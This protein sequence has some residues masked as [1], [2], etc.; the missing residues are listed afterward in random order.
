[1]FQI[2]YQ[3]PLKTLVKV[4]SFINFLTKFFNSDPIIS[5]LCGILVNH[6]FVQEAILARVIG[7]VIYQGR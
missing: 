2:K 7:I 1:M 4:V 5:S 6:E 3:R